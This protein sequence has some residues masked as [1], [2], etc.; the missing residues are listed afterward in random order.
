MTEAHLAILTGL[1]LFLYGLRTLFRSFE[2]FASSRVRPRLQKAFS[3]P[4]TSWCLGALGTVFGQSGNV[5][6]IGLMALTE[7][8]FISLR[9]AF[10]AMLG[11]SAGTTVML[12]LVVTGWH[13]GPLLLTLGLIGLLAT[14]SE[15][16][17]EIS[18]ALLSV[19]LALLG[20]Q[21]LYF[22]VSDA[23][24]EL[25]S[26]AVNHSSG[27]ENLTEQLGFFALGN[28]LGVVLQSAS[29]PLSLLLEV[30]DPQQ[31]TL[32]TGIA[33]FLGANLGLTLAVVLLSFRANVLAKRLAWAYVFTKLVGV[34]GTLFLFPTF[35]EIVERTLGF[36]AKAPS[37]LVELATAQL[38]FNLINSLVFGLLADPLLRLLAIRWPD[39]HYRSGG[40]AKPVRR[41]LAQDAKQA[42]LELE[43]QLKLL[44]LEVKANYDRVLKR[45]A[46]G[47]AKDPFEQRALRERNF[48][49]LKFTIHDL[50]LSIDR[51]R[52]GEYPEGIV[53]LSL[54]EFYGA[55]NRTLFRLEDHY[56][57]GLG[58]KFVL[59]SEIKDGLQHFKGLLDELWFEVLLTQKIQGDDSSEQ[60]VESH[61]EASQ[62]EVVALEESVLVLNARLGV[63]YQGYSTWLVETVGY[64]RLISSDL[65]Q[66]LQ[67]RLQLRKDPAP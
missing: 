31:L 11:A 65:G 59:P 34:V 48:R 32:A 35:L 6:V 62:K 15:H 38:I 3:N 45:L 13:L 60:G 36:F 12:W 41:M 63:E 37:L 57:K 5:T 10:F 23:Y 43:S 46:S 16:W 33:L 53:L 17:Q 24:G 25:L 22:G 52:R 55:L 27:S 42:A 58:K 39:H 66:V 56:E 14:R 29:A 26:Q 19:G 21:T 47:E 1:G 20:L 64:L 40:L 18:T 54:L 7:I 30:G 61:Q 8:G 9:S 4:L 50:L 51:H 28:I 67:R 2:S 44:E 49:S